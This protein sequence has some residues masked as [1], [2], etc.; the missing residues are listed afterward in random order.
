MVIITKVCQ[1]KPQNHSYQSLLRHSLLEY[2]CQNLLVDD[3][4]GGVVS[5]A[6]LQILCYVFQPVIAEE[7]QVKHNNNIM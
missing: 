2:C 5:P 1:R 7:R 4:P 6:S 3:T